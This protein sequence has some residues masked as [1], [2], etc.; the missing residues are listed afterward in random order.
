MKNTKHKKIRFLLIGFFVL[1]VLGVFASNINAS[2]SAGSLGCHP[3]GYSIGATVSEIT[4]EESGSYTLEVT[5]TGTDVVI[6]VY[7]GAMDNDLF[8]I[9]PSN[10]ITDNSADDLD[11][12]AD[13][14]RVE[15]DIEMPAASGEY[16]LRI[17]S[18]GPTLAGVSTPLVELDIKVT[19]G[20]V[21]Q[22]PLELIFDHNN[23]YLGGISVLFVFVGLIVF[24]STVNRRNEFKRLFQQK[25]LSKGV[26][27]VMRETTSNLENKMSLIMENLGI[28]EENLDS[29][30]KEKNTELFKNYIKKGMF[31]SEPKAHGVLIAIG[32]II[33]TI[34][35]FLIMNTTM[36]FVFGSIE[37]IGTRNLLDIAN[38]QD[39]N[40]YIHIILGSIGYVACV[41][42][43]FGTYNNVPGQKLKLPMYIMFFSWTF[44]FLYGIIILSP[45]LV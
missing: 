42:A 45:I 19:V 3:G 27:Q 15:L 8:V 20:I 5:A 36:D 17:L 21:V 29:I 40:L 4:A 30:E 39:L 11:L 37:A 18:R 44:N 28:K 6:D 1:V 25:E 10:V 26:V 24:Q 23:I 38:F 2:P 22:S 31:K 13:S 12:A 14:I 16:T 35:I 7:A 33:A 32:L 43:L 34:N 41:V 9:S